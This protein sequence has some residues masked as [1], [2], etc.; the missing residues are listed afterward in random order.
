M[1]LCKQVRAPAR[2]RR[3]SWQ[4]LA[5]GATEWLSENKAISECALEKTNRCSR[6]GGE[7]EQAPSDRHRAV[8]WAQLLAR[9]ERHWEYV[10]LAT[11]RANNLRQSLRKGK[12]AFPECFRLRAFIVLSR[13]SAYVVFFLKQYAIVQYNLPYGHW[14][15]SFHVLHLLFLI[16]ADSKNAANQQS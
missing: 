10:L 4:A 8:I 14:R 16:I 3:T 1:S 2:G 15:S 9:E 12:Y 5:E 13:V 11:Q 6:D 7:A